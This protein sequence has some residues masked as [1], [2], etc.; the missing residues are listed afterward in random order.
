MEKK[1]QKGILHVLDLHVLSENYLDNLR[2]KK[3]GGFFFLIHKINKV[4]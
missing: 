4:H 3:I 2:K 1:I